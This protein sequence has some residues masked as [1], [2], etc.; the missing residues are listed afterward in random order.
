MRF[1][2]AVAGVLIAVLPLIFFWVGAQTF[3]RPLERTLAFAMVVETGALLL[4]SLA[5][6]FTPSVQRIQAIVL[7]ATIASTGLILVAHRLLR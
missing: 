7:F 1:V 4:L 6:F 2:T 3:L 5:L